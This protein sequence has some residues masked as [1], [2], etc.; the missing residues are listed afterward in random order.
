MMRYTKMRTKIKTITVVA[1]TKL[2]ALTL[3]YAVADVAI[4]RASETAIDD[5]RKTCTLFSLLAKGFLIIMFRSI[6]RQA[7]RQIVRYKI[8]MEIKFVAR[9]SVYRA[10]HWAPGLFEKYTVHA[11]S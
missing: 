2:C 3:N 7:L 9:S 8:V 5:Q 10:F 1:G 6:A 11:N 4:P